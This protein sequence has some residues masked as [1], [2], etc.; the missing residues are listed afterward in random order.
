MWLAGSTV[1]ILFVQELKMFGDTQAC[2]LVKGWRF[3]RY[4]DAGKILLLGRLP[5]RVMFGRLQSIKRWA[6]NLFA[7]YSNPIPPVAVATEQSAEHIL[8]RSAGMEGSSCITINVIC[9]HSPYKAGKLSGYCCYCNV[10]FLPV[11]Y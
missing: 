9:H 2:R 6:G 8:S 7:L 4:T 3:F 10:P 5:G 11:S 1:P